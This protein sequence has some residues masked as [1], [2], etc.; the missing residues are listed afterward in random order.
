MVH[1]KEFSYEVSAPLIPYVL[2][3]NPLN[4]ADSIEEKSGYAE[5]RAQYAVWRKGVEADYV[6]FCQYRRF[7]FI[8]VPGNYQRVPVSL[9]KFTEYMSS[10]KWWFSPRHREWDILCANKLPL[11]MTLGQQYK[12]SHVTA[13]WNLFEKKASAR[14]YD[15]AGTSYLTAFLLFIMRKDLFCEWME[16][17][18][19]LMS[20]LEPAIVAPDGPNERSLGFLSER[21]FSLWVDK[22]EKIGRSVC[23]CPVLFC[24]ELS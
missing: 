19:S 20:E 13:H 16:E 22:Q 7:P 12:L 18:W 8:E 10:M 23:R 17:W 5:M 6:G 11:G 14:G 15:V 24:E 9:E 2:G 21:L 1:Y 4:V 3:R